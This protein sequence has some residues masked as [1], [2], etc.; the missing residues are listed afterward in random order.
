MYR[1]PKQ[2]ISSAVIGTSSCSL[3]AISLIPSEYFIAQLNG[4]VLYKY[5]NASGN[6]NRNQN[7]GLQKYPNP[8]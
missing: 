8:S 5:K 3:T 2:S 6:C 1:K 7:I 4:T